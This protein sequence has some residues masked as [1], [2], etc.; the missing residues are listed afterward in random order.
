MEYLS[1]FVAG[2]AVAFVAARSLSASGPSFLL[3]CGAAFRLTL[4]FRPPDLSEDV[5][6]YLWDGRVARAGVSPWAWPPD[7]PRLANLAPALSAR[8]AHREIR[9]VYP[10]AAEAIFRAAGIGD[11]PFFLKSLFAAAD[12]GV[13]AMLAGA[14]LPGGAFAAALYA[15]HPLP[16]TETAGQGHVDAVGVALLVAALLHVQGGRRGAAGLALGLS[17]MTKYVSAAAALPLLKRGGWRTLLAAAAAGAALWAG[18]SRGGVSPTGGLDQY[19]TR[20]EFNS[21]AYPAVF[22]TMEMGAVPARAKEAFLAWKARHRDPPWTQKVFPYFYSA[23][24]ARALLALLLGAILV[25][26]AW[27]GQ[28]L[29]GS[30]LASVGALLLLSPTLH[31]WYAL[32]AFPFAAARREPSFLWLATVLPVAYALVYPV[33]GLPPALVYGIEYVPF[34]ALLFWTLARLR[35]LRPARSAQG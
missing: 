15:F 5:W 32:W 24:F 25:A 26:I 18:A 27:R 12:L 33:R 20:W 1:L 30:V 35:L 13:V 3:L 22:A 29:W 21:V 7:D 23:F 10:P 31:P 11:H 19:A 6:R 14:G 4:L 34:G 9:T 8:V 16:V 2:S 17:A 28:D